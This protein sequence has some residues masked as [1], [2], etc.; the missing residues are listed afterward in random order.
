M[1]GS[2]RRE[3]PLPPPFSGHGG[4][5]ALEG[6]RLSDLA[7][8]FGT[9]LYVTSERRIRENARRFLDAFRSSWPEYRLL[10][11]M[12]ANPNPAIVRILRTEGCGADCSSPAEIRIAREAGVPALETLYTG[13]YP[14]DAELAYAVE[15]G[16]AINLDDPA[17]FPRL[18]RIGLPSLLSFRVNPGRSDSGPEGLRFAGKGAKFGVPLR[19]AIDGYRAAKRAGVRRFGLHTMPGSNVLRTEH[20]RRLGRF[21]G[22]ATARLERGAAISIDLLDAGGGFGVPYRPHDLPLDLG[23]VAQALTHGVLRGMGRRDSTALPTLCN[24][25]GR[26][27]VAD[28]TVLLT[29]VTHVKAGRPLLVGIDAGMHTLLRPALY[30]AHHPVHPL[31]DSDRPY[32]TVDLVGPVCENTDVI[33]SRRIVREPHVGDLF[34]IGNAGAYGFSMA[35]HYNTRPKPAELLVRNGRATI[36]RSAETFDDLVA[37]VGIPSHL[38]GVWSEPGGRRR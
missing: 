35:S 13:A 15:S 3:Y 33:A 28:S 5:S 1:S 8:R 7:D 26:Y 4:G 18:T 27:L 34:A 24:E 31:Q 19:R 23:T 32:R 30:G 11:A 25:P 21:L 9:P 36:I 37:R 29:R 12:K 6:L 20:F 2:G 16:V 14:S 10:Y 17:L 22:R 38:Q